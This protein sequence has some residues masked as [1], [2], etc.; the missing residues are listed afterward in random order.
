MPQRRGA[1]AA[2]MLR[3]CILLS[4]V[5][6]A[7]LLSL[8]YGVRYLIPALVVAAMTLYELHGKLVATNNAGRSQT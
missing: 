7:S 3:I 6:V 2:F 1:G 4:V 5:C 8:V